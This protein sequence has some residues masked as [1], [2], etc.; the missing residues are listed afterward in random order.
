MLL[1]LN[2]LTWSSEYWLCVCLGATSML[3]LLSHLCTICVC[4]VLQ[5]IPSCSLV[6]D[7]FGYLRSLHSHVNFF[8]FIFY[9]LV[10]EEFHWLNLYS[11]FN[12]ID[13]WKIFCVS[14][15]LETFPSLTILRFL[16]QFFVVFTG[17][18]LKFTLACVCFE[19]YCE[20]DCLPEFLQWAE[21]SLNPNCVSCYFAESAYKI[22][23]ASGWFFGN[24]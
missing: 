6:Q 13:F 9:F 17:E 3:F 2:F 14:R 4:R 7:C 8:P 19:W 5:C 20:W 1:F 11:T 16:H 21:R 22:F 12:S 24:F 23:K 15:N 10:S 18:I